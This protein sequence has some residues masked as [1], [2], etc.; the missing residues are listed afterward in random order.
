MG[1]R[2]GA[3]SLFAMLICMTLREF[4]C[5]LWTPFPFS[6]STCRA[7]ILSFVALANV[8]ALSQ[9]GWA[10][11]RSIDGSGNNLANPLWGSAGTDYLR[12]LS[13]AH[14]ADGISMPLVAGL[15]SARLLS[16]ALMTQ[17]ETSVL[18]SRG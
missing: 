17:G 7:L 13:G 8:L 1:H 16:N 5:L 10:E 9:P 12:E 18:D 15:P 6:I 4:L 11:D 14:Y 2:P 3:A